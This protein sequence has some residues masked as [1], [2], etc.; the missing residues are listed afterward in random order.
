L[1]SG[2]NIGLEITMSRGRRAV[3]AFVVSG[4]LAASSVT[5]RGAFVVGFFF[6]FFGA[7][8]GL[9]AW[10]AGGRWNSAGNTLLEEDMKPGAIEHRD[11]FV[12]ESGVHR[13]PGDV[14][15]LENHPTPGAHGKF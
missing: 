7:I 8:V 4:A 13:Y 6:L 12:D 5:S 2:R 10:L 3:L 11:P 14:F 1:V 9:L 15:D